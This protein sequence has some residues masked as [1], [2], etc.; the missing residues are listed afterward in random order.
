MKLPNI[1]YSVA[2]LSLMLGASAPPV[3]ANEGIRIK[4]LGRIET[5]RDN[6][7]V[8]YGLV[9]GLAGTGDS[10]RSKATLQSVV[11]MLDKFGVNVGVDQLNSRNV[12]AVMVITNLPPFT[13]SGDKL[14]VNVSSMGDARSLVGGTL[15]MTPLYGPDKKI[16]ALAQGPLSVGGYQYDLN[17][18]LVQK[19]HPTAAMIPDGAIVE[20]AMPSEILGENG[21]LDIVL[22]NPDFTTAQRM[23]V[24]L[25]ETFGENIARAVDAGHIQVKVTE[26]RQDRV[27]DF[28]A[29]LENLTVTPDQRARVVV[30]ERTGTIVSGGDVRISKVTVSH[31]D[32]KVSIVTDYLVSQ[33]YLL[34]EPGR[35][36]R[37]A[38]VPQ[39]RID[40]NEGGVNSVSLPT[41]TT[42]ADLVSALNRIK[43]S[44]RDIIAIL[45]GIKRSGALHA[46]LVI[47]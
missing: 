30:N 11:N 16:Y 1:F 14:D 43:S 27:V 31:G 24:S 9:T 3:A 6:S 42:V 26:F 7:L 35:D 17:G 5:V 10:S 47:Q 45:Q 21:S 23:E 29:R 4:D 15:L 2:I 20:T 22:F 37:T 44:T 38:I 36:V 25:N 19:N 39:T 18:N 28:V 32:L 41:G 13:G 40:V 46:E 33:P 34:E 12:A 8:G